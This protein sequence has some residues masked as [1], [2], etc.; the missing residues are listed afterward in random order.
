MI[1]ITQKAVNRM[2]NIAK[3]MRNDEVGGLLTGIINKNNIIITGIIILEQKTSF[4]TF[5]ITDKALM[6]FTKTATPKQLESIIGWYHSHGHGMPFWSRVDDECFERL[7]KFLNNLCIGIVVATKPNEARLRIDTKIKGER[8]TIDDITPEVIGKDEKPWL[9]KKDKKLIKEKV[10]V[11]KS[12]LS[13]CKTC[14][15]CGGLGHHYKTL[16]QCPRCEGLGITG[17]LICDTPDK[18]VLL[19]FPNTI[20]TG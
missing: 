4:A 16:R 20:I 19:K 2:F 15:K 11:Q 1:Q 10:K 6:E 14:T 8:I 12:T 13:K 3:K 5:E 7:Y 9:S 18:K 17:G